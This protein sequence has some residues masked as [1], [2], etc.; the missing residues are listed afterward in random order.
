MRGMSIETTPLKPIYLEM[1]AAVQDS[2][3][4]ELYISFIVTLLSD[5]RGRNLSDDEFKWSMDNLSSNTLGRLIEEIKRNVGFNDAAVDGLH[6]ALKARN[7]LIH[8]FYNARANLLLSQ[9][10][11]EK[12]LQEI[13]Q[14]REQI[15]AANAM[16]DPVMNDLIALKGI[17]FE[18]VRDEIEKKF[19]T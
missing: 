11:R 7:F 8:R 5:L 10:G 13:R 2:Q 16:L 17:D 3:R 18:Q 1:G 12:V 19:E 9:T 6:K 4:L 14:K 15:N